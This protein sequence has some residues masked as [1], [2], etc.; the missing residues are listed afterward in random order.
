LGE[1]N[2]PP[3]PPPRGYNH[4]G[5]SSSNQVGGTSHYV[6]SS[7]QIPI[8]GQSQ[9]G[10]KPQVGGHNPMYGKYIP[11]L[12][13]QPWNFPFQGNQQLPG[14]K[15]LQVN[16]FVPPNLRQPYPGS[17][18]PTWGQG[19]QSND[20]FQGNIP[21]QPAHVGYVT[22]NLPPP[23]L[24]GPSIYLQTTYGPI[25]IPTVLPPQNYQFP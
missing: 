19:F 16:S 11:G 2:I 14:G 6:A 1:A 22:Q 12:Q 25:G 18:N 7:F 13:S 9:V 15:T 4:P 3:P 24:I 17:M 21:N 20:P 8:G 5:P 10:G 23:N